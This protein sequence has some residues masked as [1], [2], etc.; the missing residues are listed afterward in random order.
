MSDA[1]SICSSD[2]SDTNSICDELEHL[3]E[4]CEQLHN[5]ISAATEILQ[6]LHTRI[7]NGDTINIS[8]GGTMRNLDEV[9]EEIRVE[10]IAAIREGKANTFGQR[11]AAVLENG[12][13]Q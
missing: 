5:N 7:D 3:L 4:R 11:L 9:L 13:I 6:G 2:S 10:A 1:E 12:V 8:L